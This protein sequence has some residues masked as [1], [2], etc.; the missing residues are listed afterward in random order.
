MKS[1]FE[2]LHIVLDLMQRIN[3]LLLGIQ[4]IRWE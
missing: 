3:N 2:V 1:L 4:A